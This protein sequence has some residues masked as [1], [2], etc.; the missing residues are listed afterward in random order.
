MQNKKFSIRLKKIICKTFLEIMFNK[1]RI[2]LISLENLLEIGKRDTLK[3][4]K[5]SMQPKSIKEFACVAIKK[6]QAI[7]RSVLF[8][9]L[10]IFNVKN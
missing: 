2:S 4:F 6:T 9:L 5:K 1:K 3:L 8:Y 10:I 7:L